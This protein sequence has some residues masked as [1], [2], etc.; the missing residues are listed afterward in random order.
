[1]DDASTIF[2][3]LIRIIAN[4]DS[5]LTDY[6]EIGSIG[7]AFINSA[8]LTLVN[9]FILWKF[10][11]K[12][13]GYSMSAI[14][15]IAGFA[16]F[17]KNIFNVWPIYV[18]AILYS[19]YQ[20][21]SFKN[22][23]IITMFATAL[24]PLVSEVAFGLK[25]PFPISL[26][27]G[28]A[29]GV[30]TGFIIIPVSAHTLRAHDGYNLYN[31]GFAAGLIGTIFMS[32]LKGHGFITESRLILSNGYDLYLKVYLVS[33]FIILI[34]AGYILNGKSFKGYKDIL[35]FSGRL[36]TDFTQLMGFGIT[37]I[38]MGIMGLIGMFYVI[39]SGGVLSGPIMGALLTIIGFASFG[40]HPRNAVPIMI[41]VFLGGLT[42]VWDISS[43]VVIIAALFGT[44]LAPIA[45]EYGWFV[46]IITG[47]IHLSV[48]MSVGV[49]HGGVNL[50]NNGFSGGIVATI[51]VPI[52]EAFSKEDKK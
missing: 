27:L 14:Y 42:N 1:M 2:R 40:K 50:Y 11:I 9:I 13:N 8:L 35:W 3:G 6:F 36:I 51:L 41:G 31:I 12:I 10:K 43:T 47:F 18:G 4:R 45:G 20:K 17:G 22:F 34:L 32:L 49:L 28:I 16:L 30:L 48:V 33:F 19:I 52:I 29:A 23:V 26:A 25:F 21:R 5:L 24:A 38:N 15:T 37:L 46:G 7:A 39:I 44:T